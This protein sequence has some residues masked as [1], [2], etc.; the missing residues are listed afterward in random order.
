MSTES[1]PAPSGQTMFGERFKVDVKK[2]LPE[3]STVGGTAYMATDTDN[4]SRPVYAL[5][6][7]ATVQVRN[8]VFKQL[9]SRP[10][11]SV[12]CPSE[13]GIMTLEL[14]Q[15]VQRMVTI[16][17]R[18]TG[19]ALLSAT[20]QLHEKV[21]AAKLRQSIV[22]NILRAL[23]ALH[24]K[25]IMHRSI[26]ATHIYFLSP[27][28]DDVVIGECYSA[29]AGYG[30]PTAL[31]PLELAMAHEMGRGEGLATADY[32][33][34][35]AAV[36]CLFFG[37][38]LWASRERDNLIMARINQGSYW[39]LSGGRD[40]PGALGT[41]TRGL[42]ADEPDERWGA[43]EVLDWFEG[44]T[45]NK[46]VGLKTWA[47]NRPTS[48]KGVAYVDRR[49]LADAFARNPIEAASFIRSLD[50]TPWVQVS[51]RDEVVNE[52]T[53][54]LIGVKK[55]KG[56][57]EG[58]SRADDHR[59]VSRMCMFLHPGGPLRYKKISV[60]VDG[61][62]TLMTH[63]F[64]KD[65][66]E[67]IQNLQELLD[68][69]FLSILGD[70]TGDS[71]PAYLTKINNIRRGIPFLMNKSL[72]KGMERTLYELNPVLPCMSPRFKQSWVGSVRQLMHAL[73]RL[74]ANGG[75]K[76]ALLDR[77]I[78]AYLAAHG[79][80]LDRSFN[81][82]AAA[83]NDPVRFSMLT[84]DFFGHLQKSLNMDKLPHLTERLV[85]G[86][87]PAVKALKNRKKR[88]MVQTL[89][90]RVKKGG[91][92]SKLTSEVNLSR[93]AAED[94]REFAQA[95]SKIQKLERER[96][97]YSKKILPSDPD[98][99]RYGYSASRTIALLAVGVVVSMTM[100]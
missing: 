7:N 32:F 61:I 43:E 42:M 86:L 71:D 91:D 17:D 74:A 60:F 25:G 99:R 15:R 85:E 34:F 18:P 67:T 28:S 82:L 87:A 52:R 89:L 29:P 68:F 92:I 33:Q 62:P 51:M 12:V 44:L 27:E 69:K 3:F 96:V 93:I 75:G 9:K 94:A 40:L 53:E 46:R 88:E 45:K 72:G 56:R 78:A 19:G 16:F 38:I 65:D 14:D 11:G 73:D 2:P 36:M 22:L 6:H 21:H 23:A 98:A 66:R 57:G 20:G 59:L 79:S 8:D 84:T 30:M 4:A 63:A 54:Q 39:T 97:R 13:R 24:K 48:F 64:A 41:L 35:G 90:E 83:Q 55:G 31:D 80:D 95:R 49:L 58:M 50:F 100:F 1:A 70:L 81:S 10:I 47:M 26:K 76:N 77:H 37:E 5:V